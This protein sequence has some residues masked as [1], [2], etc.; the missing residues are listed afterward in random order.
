M[1][2]ILDIAQMSNNQLIFGYGLGHYFNI[3]WFGIG[4]VLRNLNISIDY[5][6]LTSYVK[7]GFF[8]VL[9][10]LLSLL[11]LLSPTKKI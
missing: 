5:A 2:A 1:P 6:Y 11:I 10:L 4:K 8:G 9:S 7:Q 3:T